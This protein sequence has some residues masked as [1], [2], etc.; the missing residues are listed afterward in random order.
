MGFLNILLFQPNFAHVA[1]AELI[2]RD[3][4]TDWITTNYDG[5]AQ[6]AGCP[7]DQVL[8]L[9]GSWF[10][11]TNPVIK[12]HER[13]RADLLERAENIVNIS[14][15]MIVLGSSLTKSPVRFH[16]T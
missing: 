12:R 9:N 6:K 1:A 16:K 5:L 13:A 8:E 15:L 14:D 7:Q 4:V 11:P 10:D 3:I 2:R